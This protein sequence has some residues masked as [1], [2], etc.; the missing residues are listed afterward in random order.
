MK[1][2][3]MQHHRQSDLRVHGK[4][5]CRATILKIRKISRELIDRRRCAWR[6]TAPGRA[7]P[8]TCA[9]SADICISCG[10][11]ERIDSSQT[12]STEK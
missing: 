8:A 1:H 11:L 6:I 9:R 12:A 10:T 5:A 3:L 4:P 7:G 2:A